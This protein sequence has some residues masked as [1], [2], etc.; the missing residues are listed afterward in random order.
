MISARA[1]GL[2]AGTVSGVVV[3]P[4]NAVVPNATVTLFNG[5][6]GYSKATNSDK[7]GAF[8]FDN[9]PPN[10][11]ELYASAP[12]FTSVRQKLEVRSAVPITVKVPLAVGVATAVVDISSNASAVIEND[13]TAHVDVDKNLI[14]KLPAG[15]PGSGLSTVVTLSS[16]GVA[17]DSNG[18]FHPLGDHFESNISLDGQPISDQ[19]SKIFSTQLPVNAI[20][21]IEVITG[22]VPPEFGDKTSLVV[23]AISRSG[24]NQTKPSGSINASYGTFGTT[25]E[26]A[27][28][29]YGNSKIGNFTAFNYERSRRFV[30]APEFSVLNDRGTAV[31]LFDRIDYS[32]STKNSFHLNL[33][34]ARNNFQ[35]PNTFDQQAA[36]QAQS[37]IV[38]TINLAPAWVH[39]FSPTTVLSVTPYYRLDVVRYLPTSNIFS[40]QP[41]TFGESRRLNNYGLKTD[42]SYVKGKH[43]AKFGV[44]VYRT[45]L[46]EGFHFGIT[47]PTFNDPASPD[48]LP[49]LQQYDL[50]RGGSQFLFH[51]HRVINQQAAYAQDNITLGNATIMVGA[52]FDNYNGI[53]KANMLQPRIGVSYLVKRTNTVL[54]GSYTR[55]LETPYN[56]NL[57]LSSITGAGGL[58]NG[59]LGD[60]S[61]A[62]L[63]PGRR[64]QFNAGFQQSIGRHLIFD[65][66]YFLKRTQNAF[67]FNVLFNT[68]VVF[69]I[70]W[71]RSKIDGVSARLNFTNYKGFTA[72]VVAGH[73][74]ARYFPPE[75]GGLFFNSDLPSGVFR[76][77]HDQNFQQTT[78]LQ[79]QFSNWKK[80]SPYVS[81]TWRYDSGL[82]AGA[83]TDYATA[84]GF[85]ADEQQQIGLF[86]GSTFATLANPITVCNSG[87]RGALRVRIPADGAEN[88][89][90][91]P[92]R[93]AARNLFD[94]SAGT[95]NLL[96]TDRTK[97]TLRFTI[98]NLTNK[99]ALYNFESTFSGTHFVTPRAFQI[100]SGIT[101]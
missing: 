72:F 44:Q 19:Q 56:E 73:T 4:N 6:T 7:D 55:N 66:D 17:A 96:H 16:G 94:L 25:H 79:Y 49:G 91:N 58:A 51:G 61:N 15:D 9:V 21:S 86:C 63:L 14:D 67:D 32:P 50:T 11:Y 42:L 77:D 1:Q 26:D 5:I 30:D 90:T 65:G 71:Q 20:Q 47:D 8:R 59:V 81:F 87:N 29:A 84:L 85:S 43:N 10:P 95:D 31:N 64:N 27:S 28:I 60:T 2:S 98:L 97:L 24:L 18:G 57:I 83:V 48:F 89:D 38:N 22:A 70:S 39:I 88:D 69:P 37:Q 53:T 54:R 40:D 76:I 80:V 93:I 23:N 35:T 13:P 46:T 78:Q 68:S 45:A 62:P 34:L 75:S 3:D 33:F 92:P 52:R 41:L 82:V 100:Q 101:F 99:N 74:R 36:G 12:G